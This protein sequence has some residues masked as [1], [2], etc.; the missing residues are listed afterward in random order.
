MRSVD[1]VAV[2]RLVP[3]LS[4][5]GRVALLVGWVD[6]VGRRHRAGPGSMAVAPGGPWT[7][8]MGSSRSSKLGSQGSGHDGVLEVEGRDVGSCGSAVIVEVTSQLGEE[9]VGHPAVAVHEA[10]SVRGGRTRSAGL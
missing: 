2:V 9:L 7:S 8:T 4:V 5:V 6:D 10:I 1:E 3:E